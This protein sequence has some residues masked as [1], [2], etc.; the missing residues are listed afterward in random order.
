[1]ACLARLAYATGYPSEGR[2]ES[3][4]PT[5]FEE[6]LPAFSVGDESSTKRLMVEAQ[7]IVCPELR[8]RVTSN[9]DTTVR[10]CRVPGAERESSMSDLKRQLLGLQ[11]DG[12]NEPSHHLLDLC[13]AQD[14]LFAHL[15]REPPPGMNR[16][17]VTQLVAADKQVLVRL[18]G[19][20]IKPRSPVEPV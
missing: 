20:G 8:E 6:H 11:S 16:V 9:W 3:Q 17:S 10:V 12:S 4:C 18:I 14:K 15:S 1:M 19:E 13:A 7:T 2:A 5:W